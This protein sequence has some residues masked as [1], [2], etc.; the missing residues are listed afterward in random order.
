M[1]D[2][3]I[4]GGYGLRNF[5]DDALM[6]YLIKSIEEKLPNSSIALDCTKAQY[7]KHWFPKIMFAKPYQVANKINIYGGGTL[8]YSF[9]KKVNSKPFWKKTISAIK[10]P[11]LVID[12][13]LMKQRQSNFVNSKVKKVMLGLG[14]GP[15][16]LKNAQYE[17][18]IL[19]VNNTDVICVRDT[20]SFEFVSHYNESTFHG[21]DICFAKGIVNKSPNN[22][23]KNVKS[24]GVIIRDWNYGTKEDGYKANLLEAVTLLRANNYKV[25]FIVF[26]DLR[27][28]DWLDTLNSNNEDILIWNPDDDTIENFMD[29]LNGFDLFISARFHGVIFSTLLNKPAISVAIEPKL[30]LVKENAICKVW[31]PIDDHKEQLIDYVNEYNKNYE[32]SVIDCQDL[33][34]KKSK[35]YAD[36]L[37]FALKDML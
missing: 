27:D 20:K 7:I 16:H 24:I 17:Q 30:E 4:R 2:V 18:A 29:D 9:P 22:S 10:S 28:N 13:L 14:F 15:F 25:K 1:S 3:V 26:S 11:S 21:T 23:A 31:H 5:G 6:Y 19:D 36:M 35:L 33:V 32:Q 37:N 34:M 8:Y 12:K